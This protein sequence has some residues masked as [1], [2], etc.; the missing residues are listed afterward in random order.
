M[1]DENSALWS[2]YSAGQ[3]PETPPTPSSNIPFRRDTDFVNRKTLFDRLLQ[4]CSSPASRTALVGLGGV[5]KSQLA[6]E[7]CYQTKEAASSQKNEDIWVFWV[8]AGTRTRIEEDFKKIADVV[9]IPGRNQPN[10]D[11]PQLLLVLDNADHPDVLFDNEQSAAYSDAANERTRRALWTYL[12]QASNGS[13]LITTRNKRVAFKLT[14]GHKSIIEVHPMDKDDAVAL[15]ATKAGDQPD[16]DSGPALVEALEYMPLA[17]SQAGAYIQQRAPRTSIR[18]PSAADLLSLMSFFDRQGILQSWLRPLND[19]SSQDTSEDSDASS[20]S[21][22]SDMSSREV[23]EEDLATLRNYS[24]VSINKDGDVFEMHS[25]VQL[26]TRRWLDAQ[27][28]TERFKELFLRRMAWEVPTGAYKNWEVCR[29][30]FPH[31]ENALNYRPYSETSLE[32]WALILYNAGCVSMLGGVL[33]DEGQ[34]EAAEKLFVEVM[35]RSKQKLGADHP[36]TLNSMAN[37][38][39]T[40]RN[41]GRWEAAEKLDVEVMERSKQKLGAGHPDTLNSMNNLAYT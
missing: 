10:A 24:L 9:K 25:L 2:Q 29:K 40:C 30:L 1:K 39:S 16:M 3:R 8:H 26:S 33:R 22:S 15:L 36:S 13:I 20:Q 38:A 17:I 31:A 37:L 14:G 11:I 7:C 4:A 6:I 21:D 34:W 5:G 32:N 12:P 27:K 19:G 18:R 28:E 41:Q 23:F 35:E